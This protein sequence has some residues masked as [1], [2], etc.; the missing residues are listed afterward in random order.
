MHTKTGLL[1]EEHIPVQEQ[2]TSVIITPP[3]LL[4]FL[5]IDIKS[6][7]IEYFVRKRYCIPTTLLFY[8]LNLQ[9]HRQFMSF[10]ISDRH[11]VMF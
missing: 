4:F 11:Y 10:R 6:L 2:R 8:C 9:Y 7:P 5:C 1:D 3:D